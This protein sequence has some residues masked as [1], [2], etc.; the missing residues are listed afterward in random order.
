MKLTPE[1]EFR[2]LSFAQEVSNMSEEEAKLVLLEK[3]KELVMMDAYYKQ[4]IKNAWGIEGFV[5]MG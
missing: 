4:E 5:Q 2:V 3:Y 1:Q